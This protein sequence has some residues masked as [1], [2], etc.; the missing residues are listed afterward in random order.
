MSFID[1]ATEVLDRA[2]ASLCSLIADA[3]KAQAYR[4]ITTIANMAESLSTIAP[5][6]SDEARKRSP[7]VSEAAQAD[8]GSAPGPKKSEQ[9]SWVRPLS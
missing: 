9:P 8:F 7:A 5:G 4:E 6:R 3:L 1:N 2:E